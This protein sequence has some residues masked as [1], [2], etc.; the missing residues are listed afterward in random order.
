MG[1]GPR[2]QRGL[3]PA[4]SSPW[5]QR[6]PPRWVGR[7]SHQ[8][9]FEQTTGGLVQPLGAKGQMQAGSVPLSGTEPSCLSTRSRGYRFFPSPPKSCRFH[10][11]LQ[12]L[13]GL[14]AACGDEGSA[15]DWSV[16]VLPVRVSHSLMPR[17][18]G[19]WEGVAM[20][21]IPCSLYR[22]PRSSYGRRR[23]T[24]A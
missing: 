10:C 1:P 24:L 16:G 14:G 15:K 3:G 17:P 7:I 8:P 21:D 18:Q 12:A 11:R 9:T 6:G 23:V 13:G 19:Q 20:Y 2:G 4:S 5:G 22:G